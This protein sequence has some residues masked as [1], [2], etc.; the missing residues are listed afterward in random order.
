MH[1][2]LQSSPAC[3]CPAHNISERSACKNVVPG[4]D[5]REVMGVPDELRRGMAFSIWA[6]LPRREGELLPLSPR[7]SC[8]LRG[9]APFPAEM[10]A[11]P[12]GLLKVTVREAPPLWW[13]G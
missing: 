13:R 4:L 2:R 10:G 3:C 12:G 11:G 7:A 8:L 6:V 1:S 5:L 9:L